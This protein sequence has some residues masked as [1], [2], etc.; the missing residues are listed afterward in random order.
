MAR[1]G[2]R[3]EP[4][5]CRLVPGS[6]GSPVKCALLAAVG[7]SSQE[8]EQGHPPLASRLHK[9]VPRSQAASLQAPRHA[10]QAAVQDGALPAALLQG[11]RHLSGPGSTVHDTATCHSAGR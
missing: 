11:M 4:G 9:A 2:G 8:S 10:V 5:R 1:C 3:L 6:V 7:S